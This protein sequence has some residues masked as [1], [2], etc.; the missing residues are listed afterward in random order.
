MLLCSL[1]LIFCV[2][3]ISA[4]LVGKAFVFLLMFELSCSTLLA[5]R[6][7][8]HT[9]IIFRV[10]CFAAFCINDPCVILFAAFVIHKW[11]LSIL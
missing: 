4:E 9:T 2:T 10:A 3:A 6:K 5:I 11:K 8:K 1:M 7:R